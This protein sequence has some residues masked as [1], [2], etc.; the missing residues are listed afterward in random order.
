VQ[1]CI[2]EL[3]E[4]HQSA[5]HPH[6]RLGTSVGDT[7]AMLDVPENTVTSYVHRARRLLSALLAAR[8]FDAR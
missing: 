5:L 8:G 3:P 1:A 7:A 6:C 4:V 2:N